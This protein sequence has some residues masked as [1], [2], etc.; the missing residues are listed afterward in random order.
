MRLGFCSFDLISFLYQSFVLGVNLL[1][2]SVRLKRGWILL[3]GIR[4]D[5]LPKA[6]STRTTAPSS[7]SVTTEP[8]N[9][10]EFCF[11]WLSTSTIIPISSFIWFVLSWLGVRIFVWRWSSLGNLRKKTT[12]LHRLRFDPPQ[13]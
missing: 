5:P 10:L 12:S 8:L 1:A 3:L 4:C 2:S 6:P 7:R 13:T 9:A 11:S